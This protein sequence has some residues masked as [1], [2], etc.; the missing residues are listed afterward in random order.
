MSGQAKMATETGG[1]SVPS[2]FHALEL[3]RDFN[4]KQ[5]DELLDNLRVNLTRGHNYLKPGKKKN[6]RFIICGGAPSLVEHLDVLRELNGRI[7]AMNH[8]ATFLMDNGIKPWGNVWWEVAWNGN[9]DVGETYE[10]MKYLVASHASQGTFD[11][12]EKDKRDILVWHVLQ[13][14]GEEPI[15]AKADPEGMLI[16]GGCTAILRS[17]NIG[18]VMGY[19]KFDLFGVD[20]S[21]DGGTHA[22]YDVEQE[23]WIEVFCAGKKFRTTPFWARQARDFAEQMQNFG[24]KMDIRVWGEGLIPHMARQFGIHADQKG[25]S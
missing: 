18:K 24:D 22:Y 14:V 11:I 4:W 19:N 21:T 20:S 16:G 2:G 13:K 10:G 5:H 3:G 25:V 7:V 9:A 6:G 1:A 8:S 15:V 12:L 17:I 23:N